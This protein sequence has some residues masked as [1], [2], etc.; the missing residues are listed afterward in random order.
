MKAL[1]VSSLLVAGVA[2]AAPHSGVLN[3]AAGADRTC[4]LMADHRVSCWGSSEP[5]PSPA[6][7][8]GNVAWVAAGRGFTCALKSATNSDDRTVWCWG[9]NDVGQLGN[10][11]G[12]DSADPVEVLVRRPMPIGSKPLS[13]VVTISAYESHACALQSD[14]T[15]WCWGE[16]SDGELGHH[17]APLQ[18]LTAV[19]VVVHDGFDSKLNVLSMAVGGEHTCAALSD[20]SRTAACWGYNAFGQVGNDAAASSTNSPY[21]VLT[22]DGSSL[23]IDAGGYISAGGYH[24]C[25]LVPEASPERNSIVCWG[26]NLRGALGNAK[27]FGSWTSSPEP[28]GFADGTKLT[29]LDS[30]SA[31]ALSTCALLAA[32]KSIACWGADNYGQLGNHR[33]V[34]DGYSISPVSVQLDGNTLVGFSSLSL[35]ADHACAIQSDSTDTAPQPGVKCWGRNNVGQLGLGTSDTSRHD[36]PFPAKGDW[37][38]FTDGFD[39][40]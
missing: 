9:K 4:A 29:F 3:I 19:E 31:G 24:T 11:T 33:T 7:G 15:M 27:Q 23:V 13:D 14:N 1:I 28:V 5:T 25:A 39:A 37:P 16:N 36:G 8:I 30:V 20:G 40:P 34:E 22:Q 32:D 18:S 21:P 10:G 35:G 6:P 26:E 17:S 2:Q 38:L 12:V